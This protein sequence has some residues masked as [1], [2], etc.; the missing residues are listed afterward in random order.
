LSAAKRSR[1]VGGKCLRSR[2]AHR[3]PT[4]WAVI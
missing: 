2:R 4:P 3:N 1:T